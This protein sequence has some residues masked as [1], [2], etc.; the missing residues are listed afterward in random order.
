[1]FFAEDEDMA[2]QYHEMI[3]KGD[4][5]P[6]TPSIKLPPSASPG[7][8]STGGSSRLDLNR[9]S[10]SQMAVASRDSCADKDSSSGGKA[11]GPKSD[12][13]S[14]SDIGSLAAGSTPSAA[15]QFNMALRELESEV[16]PTLV[17]LE[18]L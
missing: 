5:A 18:G 14:S 1:M 2:R 8:P 9:E 10:A 16:G 12:A 13:K 4:K 11:A 17:D 6:P 3:L 15:Q 7:A